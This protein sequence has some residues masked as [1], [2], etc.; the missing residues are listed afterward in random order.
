MSIKKKVL[1]SVLA[2]GVATTGG[3]MFGSMNSESADA[4]ALYPFNP[5]HPSFPQHSVYSDMLKPY[6]DASST[7]VASTMFYNHE[8]T[9]AVQQAT[10][11]NNL[12]EFSELV[13]EDVVQAR[14]VYTND[15]SLPELV[16]GEQY[17][18]VEDY[19]KP[20]N[21][22][23]VAIIKDPFSPELNIN[24]DTAKFVGT[25]N[26]MY[27]FAS[28][29]TGKE[30][31]FYTSVFQNASLWEIPKNGDTFKLEFRYANQESLKSAVLVY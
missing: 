13:R 7:I 25:V 30:Y 11:D 9:L 31:S 27:K 20:T 12:L 14:D 24:F 29:E 3:F 2:L 19:S 22:R 8:R 21:K 28:V 26:G 4:E 5:S 17:V 6:Y 23:I 15:F 18:I 1:A 16:D 10:G